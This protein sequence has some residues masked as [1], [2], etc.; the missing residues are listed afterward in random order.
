MMPVVRCQGALRL[1]AGY[2]AGSAKC[3][4]R[5][6][7]SAPRKSKLVRESWSFLSDIAGNPALAG[8]GWRVS[9]GEILKLMDLAAASSAIMHIGHGRLNTLAFDH[10]ESVTPI[11]HGDQIHVDS[12]VVHV[13]TSTIAVHCVGRKKDLLSRGWIHTHEGLVVYV[14]LGAN[15]RPEP[16]PEL[17]CETANEQR[18][19]DMVIRRLELGKQYAKE[20]LGITPDWKPQS[21]TEVVST[22]K[23]KE[24]I[25]IEDTHL[26]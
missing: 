17:V 10:L 15:G 3:A 25:D 22:R 7:S 1:V 19:R 4:I 11:F 2:S 18:F 21:E 12:R 8:K 13:G 6:F 16:A 5:S 9:T 23:Y 24:L 14:A 26:R 20:Q